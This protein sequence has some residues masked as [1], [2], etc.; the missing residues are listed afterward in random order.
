MQK[1]S[2]WGIKDLLMLLF[3]VGAE[4]AVSLLWI[5][6]DLS[7]LIKVTVQLSGTVYEA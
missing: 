7:Y 3:L 6:L 2:Q 4:K 1:Q 5:L